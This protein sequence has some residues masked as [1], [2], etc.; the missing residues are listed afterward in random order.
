MTLANSIEKIILQ[1]D[2]RGISNLESYLKSNF[3]NNAAK[4]IIENKGTIFI[5][6]GFYIA[7]ANAPETDGPPSAIALGNT[8]KKLGNEVVY[9]T[10]KWSI[11]ILTEMTD[12]KVIDFPIDNHEK[13]ENFANKII[14][15][16][17]PSLSISI[18]RAS[19]MEDGTYRNWKGQDISNYNAKIDYIFKNA[20]NTIGIGDGG[21]E[22]GM[23]NLFHEIKKI[24]S[25][26]SNPA[27][28]KVDNLIISSCSNWGAFGLICAISEIKLI[29]LLPTIEEAKNLI[30]KCVDLGAVE[31]LTGEKKY[32][33]DGRGLEEDSVCLND[34]HEYLNNKSI[35]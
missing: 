27:T 15:E 24:E 7:Y 20:S 26:P 11:D 14:N 6:T 25:L 21:N 33:V 32:A 1:N 22:I 30:V 18:E 17:M 2:I 8:L 23:G 16:F 34:L 5:T 4:M 9:V 19:L 3:V 35:F 28:T 31:G 13:S 12:D 10:D 29:N